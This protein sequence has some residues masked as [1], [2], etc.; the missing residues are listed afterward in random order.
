P[1]NL[2]IPPLSRSNRLAAKPE[3][4][5]QLKESLPRKRMVKSILPSR[6]RVCSPRC[7]G[8]SPFGTPV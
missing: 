3:I 4:F 8:P 1:F 7:S 6:C 2:R 5:G